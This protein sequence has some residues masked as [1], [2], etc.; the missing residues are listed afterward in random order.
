MTFSGH[1]HPEGNRSERDEAAPNE[2]VRD[3]E[4]SGGW[5]ERG[6]GSVR[7]DF[8]NTGRRLRAE[9]YRGIIHA[10]L[11]VIF[12]DPPTDSFFLRQWAARSCKR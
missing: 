2:A 7:V 1:L 11:N 3:T 9:E 8:A 6:E 5:K 4:V 12:L 10:G